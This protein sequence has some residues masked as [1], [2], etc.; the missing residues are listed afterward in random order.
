M[1][2]QAR[3][4]EVAPFQICDN[5]LLNRM[6]IDRPCVRCTIGAD[7]VAFTSTS[8]VY[9]AQSVLFMLLLLPRVCV[10][11]PLLFMLSS[12]PLCFVL[13]WAA[14]GTCS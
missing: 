4:R 2:C 6:A 7:L 13:F 5:R 12:L 3:A 14:F 11:Q 8:F 9:A 1:Q 10:A